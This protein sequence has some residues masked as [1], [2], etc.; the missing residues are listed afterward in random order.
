[1]ILVPGTRYAS[2]WPVY[3]RGSRALVSVANDGSIT[4]ALRRWQ[5]ASL[6]PKIEPRMTSEQVKEDILRQLRPSA[7]GGVHVTVD[8]IVLAYYDG[9]ADYL[10]P[11]Y[12]FEAVFS[13]PPGKGAANSKIAGY[14]PVGNPLEPIPDLA[15]EPTGLRPSTVYLPEC[16]ATPV[17]YLP[18]SVGEFLN[19]DF[20]YRDLYVEMSRQFVEGLWAGNSQRPGYPRFYLDLWCAAHP[21]QVTGP[22]SGYFMNAVNVAYTEP[23]GAWLFNTTDGADSDPWWVDDIRYY[24]YP[25]FGAATGGWLATWVIFSCSVIPSCYDGAN[26]ATGT[27]ACSNAWVPWWAVFQGLHNVLGFR[28]EAGWPDDALNYGFGF[29]AALGGDVNGA[30]LQEV[31][32]IHGNDDTYCCDTHLIGTPRVHPDR[33]STFVDGRDLGQSIYNV[34]QQT[35]AATT[36]CNF[37]MGN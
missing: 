24:G 2:G 36:L 6:G 9:N 22:Q 12:E 11:V 26:Q 21:Y 17:S 4:G 29:D 8:K 30:W 34:T 28:T 10:Q 7:R 16:P 15:A 25:G 35:T 32:A 33:A 19:R 37:W 18:I 27:P 31:G 23:H 5:T 13:P 3:G 14:V 1:M 20:E